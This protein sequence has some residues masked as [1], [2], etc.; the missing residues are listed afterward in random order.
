MSVFAVWLLQELN[1]INNNK[2]NK[3]TNKNED[4]Q[5]E[6]RILRAQNWVYSP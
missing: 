1:P 5:I 6:A 4:N 3:Q 2:T